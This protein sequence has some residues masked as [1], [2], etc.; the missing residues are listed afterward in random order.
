MRCD[1]CKFWD[2]DPKS[3]NNQENR[4][5]GDQKV[6]RCL[7]AVHWWDAS[8]WVA[9]DDDTWHEM[10]AVLPEYKDR[11]MFTQDGSDYFSALLTVGDFFCAHF[12]EKV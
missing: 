12:E 2:T 11:K 1:Q 4:S 10:R 6:H 3:D 8:E 7:K 5:F 9:S